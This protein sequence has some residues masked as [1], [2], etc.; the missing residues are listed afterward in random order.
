MQWDKTLQKKRLLPS[1]D[2]VLPCLTNERKRYMYD[3]F[4]HWLRPLVTQDNKLE[5]GSSSKMSSDHFE[6]FP[7]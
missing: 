4:F 5:Y 2:T 6:W 3:V 1:A 7:R